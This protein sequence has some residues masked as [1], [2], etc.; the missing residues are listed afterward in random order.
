M[1]QSY[2]KRNG[3]HEISLFLNS[4]RTLHLTFRLFPNVDS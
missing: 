1:L 4:N 2:P 3:T